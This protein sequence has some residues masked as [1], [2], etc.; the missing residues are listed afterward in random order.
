MLTV[1]AVSGKGG[2][3]K[4]T[5]VANLGVALANLGH[6]VLLLDCN[7]VNP[8]L[9]LHFGVPEFPVSLQEALHHE[10][11]LAQATVS[12]LGV[13]LVPAVSSPPR[14]LD[15]LPGLLE[16]LRGY[17]VVLMDTFP[18]MERGNRL[19]L[20]RSD[21]ALL[22]SNPDVVSWTDTKRIASQL[23][24]PAVWVTNRA[25]TGPA[26]GS[27]NGA[28]KIAQWPEMDFSLRRG[29]PVAA[30]V[31]DGPAAR[32]YEALARDL[33]ARPVRRKPRWENPGAAIP[34]RLRWVLARFRQERLG[35]HS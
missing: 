21:A 19:L 25:C 22:V 6:R 5:T 27:S 10:L 9:R 13:D 24:V 17:D 4:T 35:I 18:G 14:S 31:K 34:S 33:L 26:N 20:D 30:L 2:V 16:N 1:T 32:T 29:V 12:R 7:F 11:D 28:V 3:G 8:D 15:P 23:P